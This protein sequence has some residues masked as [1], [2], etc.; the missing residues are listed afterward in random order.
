LETA[1]SDAIVG[2]VLP[3]DLSKPGRPAA[4]TRSAGDAVLAALARRR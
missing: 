2:G 4:N 3:A 1:V